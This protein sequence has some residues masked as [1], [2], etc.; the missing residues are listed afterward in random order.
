MQETL[1]RL[2]KTKWYTKLDV[3]DAYNMIRI[4]EED[5]WKTA[6]RTRYGLFESFVM[7]FGVT[8]APVSFQ[9]FINDT[10]RPFLDIFCTAFLNNIVIYS[11]SFTEHKEHV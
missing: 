8:N 5:E 4:A 7:P 10:L 3:W 2:S 1:L 6:F 9:E 11:D